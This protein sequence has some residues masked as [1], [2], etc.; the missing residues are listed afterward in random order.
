MRIV[1]I[2]PQLSSGGAERFVVDLCNEL[3]KRHEVSLIVFY[4]I[5]EHG[6]YV[7]E[8]ST[9]VN[10]ICLHKN[11]GFSLPLMKKLYAAVEEINPDIV[12]LHTRAI[13]YAWPFIL[14][15]KRIKSFMTIHSSAEKEA[16]GIF[17]RAVRK[18]CFGNKHITPV[19]ISEESL[20]SFVKYY[21]YAAP[22]IPNGR[23]VDDRLV[24]SDEVADEF[25]KYKKNDKTKVLVNLARFTT[26]KRQD[27]LSRVAD[28]LSKE[29]YDLSV[30]LIGKHL[31][32]SVVEKVKTVGCENVHLL[33]EKKNPLEY[34][35][36]ADAFCLCS[37]YEGMPISLIEA[38]GLGTIPVCTPVGG[39]VNVVNDSN[40]FLSSDIS[41]ESYY[42]ALKQ[43]LDTDS[44][45]LQEMKKRARISY[46]PYSMTECA[47][48]YEA[49]F[50][51]E[52][53]K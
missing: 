34:L 23:N 7:N 20:N 53:E 52:H 30:L 43:F 38:I 24:V 3:S 42:L 12:H 46:Q 33:G 16:G 44:D 1:E 45:E 13:N 2:I 35:K 39:I 6:F 5:F 14:Q 51:E 4:D 32:E 47:A 18:Y 17:E 27:L 36:L 19:T 21:G 37:T 41:E 9:E 49:L 15:N 40:G 25:K 22:M 29:G 10:L 31:D 50:N 48:K 26:V 11:K 28:R 8:L